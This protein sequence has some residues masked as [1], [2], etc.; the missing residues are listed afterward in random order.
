MSTQDLARFIGTHGLV[1]V[2]SGTMHSSS[3]HL[4]DT[5]SGFVQIRAVDLAGEGWPLP[6]TPTH[7]HVTELDRLS[8]SGG[9]FG[10]LRERI[11]SLLGASV[12]VCISGRRASTAYPPVIASSILMDSAAF[13]LDPAPG[14]S[15]E[16]D[17]T[18]KRLTFTTTLQEV[19]L[20]TLLE[21]EQALFDS[22]A[23]QESLPDHLTA[24]AQTELRSAGLLRREPDRTVR[25]GP[26]R[27][28]SELKQAVAEAVSDVTEAPSDFGEISTA[29]FSIERTIRRG[30]RRGE[31]EKRGDRWRR[32]LFNPAI[33]TEV[34]K[35]AQADR[36][37]TLQHSYELRDPLEW[38]SLGELISLAESLQLWGRSS[39][40]WRSISHDLSPI[41]NRISHMRVPMEPDVR[42]ARRIRFQIGSLSQ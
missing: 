9:K 33:E 24:V 34:V 13:Y 29:L 18:V 30:L 38:L 32:G 21:L 35:R 3:N 37:P 11:T 6:E 1:Y 4:R 20:S 25:F 26:S 23:D 10:T 15:F 31:V 27:S 7:L 41:R 40:F 14:A 28:F 19:S 5:T 17:A 39:I 42:I 2:H 8:P 36:F 12:R 22:G 16:Q